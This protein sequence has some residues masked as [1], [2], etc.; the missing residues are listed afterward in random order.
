MGYPP[1]RHR[2][3]P[4]RIALVLAAAAWAWVIGLHDARAEAPAVSLPNPLTLTDALAYAVHPHP[5]TDRAQLQLDIARLQLESARATNSPQVTLDAVPRAVDPTRDTAEGLEDDSFLQLR[6][7]LP[8]YDFGRTRSRLTAAIET[9][10]AQELISLE[11]VQRHKLAILQG[12]LN[13]VLADMRYAIDNELMT[14]AFLRFDRLRERRE[15]FDEVSEIDVYSA[16]SIYRDAFARRTRAQ[17]DRQR[18]RLMLAAALGVPS[19]VPGELAPADV[20]AW[21]TREIPDFETAMQQALQSNPTLLV[22]R[23]HLAAAD[24]A[25]ATAAAEYRPTLNAEIE[26]SEYQRTRTSR[27]DVRASLNLSV[28]LYQGRH[29]GIAVS[30]A[31]AEADQIRTE[32]QQ[33]RFDVRNELFTLLQELEVVNIERTAAVTRETYRDLYMDRSRTLYEMEVRS[34][35]GDA[36]AKLLEASWLSRRA[37]FK[38]AVTWA[39]L[40]ALLGRPVIPESI[41]GPDS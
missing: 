4:G 23:H 31:K 3:R 28:P 15:L 10:A 18:L 32:L 26:L 6:A 8:I 38:L 9:V 27:D 36:Q 25:T 17:L 19:Q 35:L 24:A 33:L 2:A 37:D 41:V 21:I 22:A 16:E 12:Y 39:Q 1:R 14:L 20:S 29:R 13:V 11:T 7:S 40:D 5:Q 34:D 30:I